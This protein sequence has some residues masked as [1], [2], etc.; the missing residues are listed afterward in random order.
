MI[1]STTTSVGLRKLA[2]LGISRQSF[3]DRLRFLA[4]AGWR[5]PR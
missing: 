4:L 1:K 5:R 2:E 3:Y